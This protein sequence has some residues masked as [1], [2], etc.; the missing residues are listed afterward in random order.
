MLNA[1]LSFGMETTFFRYLN[2][3]EDKKQTVYDNA[4][5][6]ILS[7]GAVFFAF[8][9]LFTDDIANWV[10]GNSPGSHPEY[11]LYI[12]YFVYILV[13]DAICVI[14]FA[15]LRADGRPG[16]YGAIKTFNVMLF[17][18]LNIFFI[19]GIPFLINH[20]ITWF[21]AWFRPQ[22]IGYVFL[23]NLIASIATLILLLP[24]IL[25]LRLRVDG[26][27]L[28]AMMIYSFPV[29]VANISFIINENLDKMMLPKLLPANLIKH[30]D[31][32]IY[33]A[34]CKIA[35]FLSIFVQAFRLGAEPFFFSHAKNKNAGE[36]YARIMNYFVIAVALIFVALTANIDI[37]KYFIHGKDIAQTK[38]YWSGL[39]V[40][41]LLLFGYV[42]L[43]IYINLSIW[44]KLSDQTK[45]GL[46]ISGIGAILTIG[47]NW[48]FIPQYSYL[49]SAWA[50]LIAYA[51]MMV[52]SYFWGQKNY[53]IPY[54]LKKN[55][56]YI[57]AS[58]L[59]VFLSFYVFKRNIFI[60]NGLLILF[61]GAA[62][63][64]ERKE[65]MQILKRK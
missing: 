19:K 29:F 30:G 24:Q 38:L 35:V 17:I 44:Y 18:C 32:G 55:V 8:T 54:N 4:F 11:V 16:K 61:A 60:G 43:G 37:M 34:N 46:Y 64:A 10:Q 62:F 45:Y 9:F 28:K 26:A 3:H 53:P 20:H 27:M 65:L 1:V 13:T 50:S 36:T 15:K 39:D 41:P 47:I 25:K 58:I 57:G 49:A 14:P 59:I 12:K 23:S 48:I 40:V 5:L 21:S 56:T 33:T 31:V 7:V 2:K 63:L 22:W 6:A 51:T 52:L 42:S